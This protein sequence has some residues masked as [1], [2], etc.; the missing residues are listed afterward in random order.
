MFPPSLGQRIMTILGDAGTGI[1]VVEGIRSDELPAPCVLVHIES[2]ENHNVSLTDVFR[3]NVVV[4]YEEHYADANSNVVQ[5]NF[6][7]LI[8]QFMVDNLTEKVGSFGY[9]VF[10]ASVGN[11]TTD[12][13]NDFFVNEFNLEILAERK[14]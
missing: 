4:R 9:H 1:D 11:I 7:L 12:I 13:E 14:V 8:D 10:Q 6:N 2:A 3:V 5:A